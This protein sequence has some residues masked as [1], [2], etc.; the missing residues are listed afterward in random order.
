ML[1]ASVLQHFRP[2]THDTKLCFATG[3]VEQ[4]FKDLE[5]QAAEKTYLD[6]PLGVDSDNACQ[7]RVA[8]YK[9]LQCNHR[10][11]K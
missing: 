1:P 3:T 7:F 4:A 8:L 9:R 6:G 2:H 10:E 11:E 5:R